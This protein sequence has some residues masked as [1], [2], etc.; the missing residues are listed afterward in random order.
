MDGDQSKGEVE[1]EEPAIID[2]NF[3]IQSVNSEVEGNGAGLVIFKV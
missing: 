2:E 1:S 3:K